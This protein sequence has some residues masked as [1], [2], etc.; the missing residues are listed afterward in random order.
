MKSPWI[1]KDHLSLRQNKTDMILI[2]CLYLSSFTL[3]GQTLP[4]QY[5]RNPHSHQNVRTID[6]DLFYDYGFTGPRA[7][8]Y[9]WSWN[10]K[11]DKVDNLTSSF[12]IPQSIMQNNSVDGSYTDQLNFYGFKTKKSYITPDMT[13][14]A[15]K[16]RESLYPL[17][18]EWKRRTQELNLNQRE[19]VEMLLNFLQDV[20]YGV[21]P[22]TYNNRYIH[23]LFPPTAMFTEKFGDCDSKSLAFIA[24]LSWAPEF[25]SRM[26]F[27]TVPGHMLVGIE[28]VARPYDQ[29]VDWEGKRYVFLEPV[30]THHSL[31]GSGNQE[32]QSILNVEPVVFYSTESAAPVEAVNDKL[33]CPSDAFPVDFTSTFSGIRSIT[34]T[35]NVGGK[36]IKHGPQLLYNSA[37]AVESRKLFQ[38]DVEI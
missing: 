10:W 3:L 2:I 15:E 19:S 26:A 5:E 24:I 33:D 18:Q 11:L 4:P 30:G 38:D 7:G 23:G 35:K 25:Q 27:I 31:Y 28:D 1:K 32:Y 17:Y 36:F 14:L 12:G 6:Y 21:P 13:A 16:Y 34:C 22:E 37:G 29:F 9:I 8:S 20:P